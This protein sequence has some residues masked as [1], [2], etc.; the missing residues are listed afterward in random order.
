MAMK[1][2][3]GNIVSTAKV[4]SLSA[5]EYKEIIKFI[6]DMGLSGG[7]IYDALIVKVASKSSVSTLLT[8][9]PGD[10][11]RVWPKGK[12]IICLP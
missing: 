1:L 7:I 11:N 12:E 9:N 6:A 4:V 2:I 8:L 10:F 3:N 5:T